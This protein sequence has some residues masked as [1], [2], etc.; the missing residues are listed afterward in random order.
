[1]FVTT[2]VRKPSAKHQGAS[3]SSSGSA[4][5]LSPSASA[6]SGLT[7]KFPGCTRTRYFDTASGK[8]FEFCGKTC[9][10]KFQKMQASGQP[11]SLV[12]N[13]LHVTVTCACLD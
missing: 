9:G 11:I 10:Q 4:R 3:E 13:T 12:T 7:C 2:S 5:G 1:M 8:H 6:S